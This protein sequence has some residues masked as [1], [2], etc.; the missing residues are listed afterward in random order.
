M[1]NNFRTNLNG[2]GHGLFKE[3]SQDLPGET[4]EH[5]KKLFSGKLAEI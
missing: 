4:G 5:H 2:C 3:L 1:I